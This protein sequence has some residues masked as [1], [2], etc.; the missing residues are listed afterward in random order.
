[1]ALVDLTPIAALAV[2]EH[3][4]AP[5][6]CV[7]AAV[8]TRNNVR[9]G[10]GAAGRLWF[11][12]SPPAGAG[13]APPA[14]TMDAIFDLASVTKPFTALSFARLV[15]AG[16]ARYDEPLGEVLPELA[17]TRSAAVPLEL[18]AAHRAGLEAHRTLHRP[19][20]GAPI[21]PLEA[22][23]ACADAR[24]E[25]CA[26][27]PPEGGFPPVYSDLGY[28]LLGAAVARR[29]EAELDEVVAREVTGPLGLAVASARALRRRDPR[30]DERV[31]PTE[32]VAFRGGVIRG[33]VHDDN[34]WTIA[35]DGMAGH[36]GLFGDAMSVARLGVALLE[37]L[38]GERPEW[39]S[40]DEVE[41]LIEPRPGG[42]LRAGFDGKSGERPSA[43]ARF[44]PRTFGHLGFTGT[45]L[46][47]DP[48]AELV[49][50]LLTNR[51]HPTRASD[52]IRRARPAVYDAI[53][54]AMAAAR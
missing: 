25:G 2:E 13:G 8:R 11:E 48:D 26:G 38:A 45:S 22:L 5:C 7:A 35:Q 36:A 54:E 1:M 39:L 19:G 42:S 3:S 27:D 23:L 17:G 29:G 43:G 46:W 47:I 24:R 20:D 37:A 44:G 16:K 6:A 49:G 53:A 33:A 41:R 10:S 15:R 28:L 52:A 31:I 18:L 51:V 30:F 34:A 50:V 9:Y 14:A 32:D 40:R 4:A 21:D 12:D